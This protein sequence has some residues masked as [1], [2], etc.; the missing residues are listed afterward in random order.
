LPVNARNIDAAG[1]HG[2]NGKFAFQTASCP[3]I[4]PQK[5]NMPFC[6]TIKS[7]SC[8]VPFSF[9]KLTSQSIRGRLKMFSDGLLNYP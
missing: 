3:G 5:E 7:K 2:I 6:F 9:S 4:K 1:T 8:R